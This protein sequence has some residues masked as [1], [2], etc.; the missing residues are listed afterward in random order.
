MHL[1]GVPS[2]PTSSTTEMGSN[3]NYIEKGEFANFQNI[4]GYA[5]EG[6]KV[7]FK[8]DVKIGIHIS[9]FNFKP[10]ETLSPVR[11]HIART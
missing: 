5:K 6:H 11:R 7:V 8:M 3:L 2:P 4:L 9:S 10:T 1:T